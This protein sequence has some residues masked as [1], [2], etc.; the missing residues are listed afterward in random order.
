[1][2]EFI[3]YALGHKNVWFATMSEVSW[4]HAGAAQTATMASKT[5]ACVNGMLLKS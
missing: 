1:M 3:D 4:R 5:A 2:N